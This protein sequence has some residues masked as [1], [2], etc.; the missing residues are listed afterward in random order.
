MPSRKGIALSERDKQTLRDFL[1]CRVPAKYYGLDARGNTKFDF[2]YNY[3]EIYD[4]AD[5]L[6]HGQEVSLRRNFVGLPAVAINEEFRKILDVIGRRD[7]TLSDF[8]DK[9]AAAT[10]VIGRLARKD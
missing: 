9:L 5:A 3:E 10:L 2:N 4:Y 8:C 1:S 6:L 7:I